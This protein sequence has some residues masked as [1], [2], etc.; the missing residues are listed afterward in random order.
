MT[1]RNDYTDSEWELLTHMPRLAAFGAMAAEE[2]GTVASI[3]ELWTSM[4]A[5]PL[6][7]SPAFAL[8][9]EE[10]AELIALGK[11]HRDVWGAYE[12]AEEDE[13]A[14]AIYG[15]I[16]DL[17]RRIRE[18]PATSLAGLAAKARAACGGTFSI[19]TLA[20]VATGGLSVAGE[21]ETRRAA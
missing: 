14:A 16:T 4:M 20:A 7:V 18:T 12:A 17:E 11:E 19:N 6:F 3:R 2:G 21:M 5:L 9:D 13:E 15:Q 10:D 8:Q 1:T